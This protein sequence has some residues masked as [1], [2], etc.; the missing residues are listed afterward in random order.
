MVPAQAPRAASKRLQG[1]RPRGKTVSKSTFIKQGNAFMELLAVPM[2]AV[3]GNPK[4]IVKRC[5]WVPHI[6]RVE[7]IL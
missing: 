3:S 7:I 4:G 2:T 1:R 6:D 5:T